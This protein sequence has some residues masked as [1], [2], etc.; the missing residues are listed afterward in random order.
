M[1]E[2]LKAEVMDIEKQI[3]DQLAMNATVKS[4]LLANDEILIRMIHA[5]RQ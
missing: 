1:T 3:S 5:A 4:S 2:P